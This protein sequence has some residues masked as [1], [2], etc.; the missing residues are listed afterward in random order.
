MT[1]LNYEEVRTSASWMTTRTHSGELRPPRE[2]IISLIFTYIYYNKQFFLPLRNP[3]MIVHFQ[4]PDEKETQAKYF[5][6]FLCSPDVS[7]IIWSRNQI[8]ISLENYPQHMLW[9][10]SWIYRCY[11]LIFGIRTV[12]SFPYLNAEFIYLRSF[13]YLLLAVVIFVKIAATC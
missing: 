6:L 7:G 4:Q 5:P 8:F 1:L 3:K 9:F 10:V 12:F 2:I 11:F 13:S